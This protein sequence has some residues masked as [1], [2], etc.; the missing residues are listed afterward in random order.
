MAARTIVV[1]AT[2]HV[3]GRLASIVAK[4][5]LLGER[6]VIVNAD[7]AVLSGDPRM[8]V[9]AY[10]K[11]FKVT[12]HRNPER[13]GIR[14]PRTPSRILRDAI[15]GM[16]PKKPT[17]REALR[18]LRV[19]EGVPDELRNKVREFVRFPEASSSRLSSKY[20]TVGELA[21]SM[22]WKRGLR[23]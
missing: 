17:G 2:N 14:R 13:T 23:A 20:I 5:L 3:V 11:M 4:R 10:K 9:E 16:L 8:V 6:V 18:R 15:I 21:R 7:K 12:T 1:D 22:G 19:Y